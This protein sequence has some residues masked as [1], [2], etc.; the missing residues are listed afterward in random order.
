MKKKQKR[1]KE[2]NN[3]I[4]VSKK[5]FDF[6]DKI[7][8]RSGYVWH[9][10]YC[11]NGNQYVS[12][13]QIC[14]YMK[15]S[16]PN[17][18][19]YVMDMPFTQ[20]MMDFEEIERDEFSN[21]TNKVMKKENDN[22]NDTKHFSEFAESEDN[23]AFMSAFLNELKNTDNKAKLM[24]IR[25]YVSAPSLKELQERTNLI[26]MFLTDNE[27][28][29]YIKFNNLKSDMRALTSFNNPVKKMVSSET[30]SDFCQR[31]IVNY[32]D[33]N[34]TVLGRTRY[35]V[36]APNIY[37]FG[38]VPSRNV[39]VIG[40]MGAGKSALI[41]K[42]LNGY[43]CKGMLNDSFV[44]QL[45]DIHHEYDDFCHEFKIPILS[46]N[47]NNNVNLCQIF[48]VINNSNDD[49][50]RRN[51]IATKISVIV[52]TFDGV[53]N[54]G[55]K[56]T[57]DALTNLLTEFYEPYVDHHLNEYKNDDW[58]LLEKV[59]AKVIEVRKNKELRESDDKDYHDILLGLEKMCGTYG[60]LFNRHTN[61][62]FNLS[63]SFCI[64]VSFL[65]GNEDKNV[66]SG[67]ISLMQD[68]L[69][70]AMRINLEKNERMMKEQ[71][72]TAHDLNEP[73]CTHIV[74]IDE[75][76]QFASKSFVNTCSSQSKYQRKAYSGTIY[77]IHSSSDVENKD[78]I[79]MHDISSVKELFKLSPHKFI[80]ITDGESILDMKEKKML[81]GIT[82]ADV[83]IISN[84]TMGSDESRPFVYLNSANEKIYF[85]SI[86][87]NYQKKYFKG[88]R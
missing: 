58:L 48:Y 67:Y 77:V 14:D 80:G 11:L 81:T 27:M 30:C 87:T 24:T 3:K 86:L 39:M 26:D 40:G 38:L 73:L 33:S 13:L 4:N 28:Y 64:D 66:K 65:E 2:H 56:E 43:L 47:E 9:E 71:N 68:Y 54:Y 23:K 6:L 35:G 20:V 60:H 51:D 84:F 34:S 78:N 44:L 21:R 15:S 32:I 74:L 22:A 8:S 75:T 18:L 69:S 19:N 82:N 63:K 16:Y 12:C 59:K 5:N 50:I 7:I 1:E 53:T 25:V 45:F 31:S 61:M 36:F 57:L 79:E 76:M 72:V 10:N 42:L 46:V 49:I 17:F 85:N 62:N 52:S 37:K 70:Q 41:K 88:A 29:G 83:E 55:R